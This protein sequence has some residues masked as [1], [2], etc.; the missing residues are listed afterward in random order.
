[1]QAQSRS[2]IDRLCAENVELRAKLSERGHGD[3][4]I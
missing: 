2:A 4:K 1:M 3:A